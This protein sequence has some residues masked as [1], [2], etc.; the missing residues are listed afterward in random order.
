[1]ATAVSIC[2]NALI[3][4]GENP[5]NSFT[6]ANGAGGLDRA[7]IAQNLWPTTRDALLRSHPWNCAIKRVVLAP[8]VTVPAF[9]YSHSFV[10][11]SDWLRNHEINGVRANEVDY[12]VESG[13]LLIDASSVNLRYVWKNDDVTS[14][15]PLLVDAAIMA[16]AMA[17]AYPITQST[18]LRAELQQTF[19]ARLRKARA[20]DGQDES[21]ATF[22][23]FEILNARRGV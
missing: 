9:G 17:M 21:P 1:M 8:E 6:E 15:D 3:M 19:E 16:M 10:L 22:G 11:P 18:S 5:I 14:W 13:R 7:R 23:S 2:S 4:L 12:T 20:V